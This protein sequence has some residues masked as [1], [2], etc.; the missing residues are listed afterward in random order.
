[1]AQSAGGPTCRHRSEPR[2]CQRQRA[3]QTTAARRVVATRESGRRWRSR[4]PL[5]GTRPSLMYRCSPKTWLHQRSA[6]NAVPSSTDIEAELCARRD[7][8]GPGLGLLANVDRLRNSPVVAPV[9]GEIP[10]DEL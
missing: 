2:S 6:R 8:L 3:L 4:L 5:L 9:R 10:G 1:M 7:L